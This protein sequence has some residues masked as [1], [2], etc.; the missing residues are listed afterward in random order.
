MSQKDYDQ[1]SE[2]LEQTEGAIKSGSLPETVAL[3]RDAGLYFSR[4]AT[5]RNLGGLD[6]VLTEIKESFTLRNVEFTSSGIQGVWLY[7]WGD[8]NEGQNVS[9][10]VMFWQSVYHIQV[11][12][13]ETNSDQGRDLRDKLSITLFDKL[14]F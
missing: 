5:T 4:G 1:V 8:G 14:G 3:S 6:N 13:A 10:T 12:I 11:T 9:V 2:A 7:A